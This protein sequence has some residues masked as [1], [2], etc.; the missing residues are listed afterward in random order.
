MCC[1]VSDVIS[2]L[3]VLLEFSCLIIVCGVGLV[4]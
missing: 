2:G 1:W 4:C 3:V